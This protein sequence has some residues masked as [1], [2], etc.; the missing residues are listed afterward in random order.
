[1]DGIIF[2]INRPVVQGDPEKNNTPL[3]RHERP[4]LRFTSWMILP[5]ISLV[6]EADA[7]IVTIGERPNP[8]LLA[9]TKGIEVNRWGYMLTHKKI[10]AAPR[11]G[12]YA[13]GD[14]AEWS[15]NVIKA[16]GGGR[17]AAKAMHEYLTA[18]PIRQ[19]ARNG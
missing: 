10:M 4:I 9:P 15:A 12:V 14:I 7:V 19:A 17:K 5:E 6:K 2:D 18:E 8:L 11:E 1:M 3:V 13:R 16:M